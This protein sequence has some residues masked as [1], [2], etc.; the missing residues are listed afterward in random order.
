MTPFAG[1]AASAMWASRLLDMPFSTGS[2]YYVRNYSLPLASPI[3]LR[4]HGGAPI[5]Q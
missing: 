1:P 5:R 2:P 3:F 4:S